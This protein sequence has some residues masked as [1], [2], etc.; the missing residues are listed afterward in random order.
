MIFSKWLII[1]NVTQADVARKLN[2]SESTISLILSGNR[3]PSPKLAQRMVNESGGKVSLEE[4]L[5]PGFIREHRR[6][7][8]KAA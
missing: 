8:G 3:R 7:D 6:G 4:A 5:F 1:A 2:V